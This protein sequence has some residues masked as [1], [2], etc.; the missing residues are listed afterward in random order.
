[1]IICTLINV[2]LIII[3][4]IYNR[5]KLHPFGIIHKFQIRFFF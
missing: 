4:T 1:M 2:Y 3:N 5:S